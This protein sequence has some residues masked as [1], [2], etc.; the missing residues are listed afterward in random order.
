MQGSGCSF[1]GND[2]PL[3]GG[4]RMRKLATLLALTA[5]GPLAFA[6]NAAA[7]HRSLIAARTARGARPGSTP[8]AKPPR[9][10]L[11]V[12]NAQF[13]ETNEAVLLLY[14]RTHTWA[15]EGYCDGGTYSKGAKG[16]LT[17]HDECAE[18][19]WREEKVKHRPGIYFG[20]VFNTAGAFEAYIELARE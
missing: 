11:Y 6:V 2:N 5:L 13:E 8:T 10:R 20:E 17:F 9:Y 7:A 15:V 19:V 18:Q 12:F 16:S 14:T 4:I 1:K 3:I